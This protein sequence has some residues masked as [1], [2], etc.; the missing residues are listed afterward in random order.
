[1]PTSSH[2]ARIQRRVLGAEPSLQMVEEVAEETIGR[3]TVLKAKDF[4]LE[5]GKA[6]F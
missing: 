4:G 3:K 6:I 1:M 5:S 2:A